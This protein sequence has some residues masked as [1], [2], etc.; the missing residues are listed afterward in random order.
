MTSSG[1]TDVQHASLSVFF[2]LLGRFSGVLAF[3]CFYEAHRPLL[4]AGAAVVG[5]AAF[6]V[7]VR[8][9]QPALHYSMRSRG[10]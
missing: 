8:Y 1:F 10:W 5:L 9:K 4:G 3:V 7:L 2:G 6:R